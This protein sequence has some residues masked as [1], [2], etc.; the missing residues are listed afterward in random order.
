ME[1]RSRP[2]KNKEPEVPTGQSAFA[3]VG[4]GLAAAVLIPAIL[5]M[6]AIFWVV[7]VI[8]K[9]VRVVIG[10]CQKAKQKRREEAGEE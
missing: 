5:V 6:T 1:R 9:P 8:T 10:L 4:R 7:R 3:E 2:R